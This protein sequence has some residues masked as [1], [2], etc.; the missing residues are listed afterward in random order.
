MK[1]KKKTQTKLF[2]TL[3]E[4]TVETEVDMLFLQCICSFLCIGLLLSVLS[5]IELAWPWT[6]AVGRLSFLLS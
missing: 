3:Y 4:R 6:A 2:W 1:T 5:G